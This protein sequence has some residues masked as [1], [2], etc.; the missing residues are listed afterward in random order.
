[1]QVFAQELHEQEVERW[2][3]KAHSYHVFLS[4][5]V[6]TL[7]HKD[8][9]ILIPLTEITSFLCIKFSVTRKFLGSCVDATSIS[10]ID[11]NERGF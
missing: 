11:D 9:N 1:M 6:L 7:Q 3:P 2:N 10:L 5:L 4:V 8:K